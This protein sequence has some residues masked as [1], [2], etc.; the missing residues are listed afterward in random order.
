MTDDEIK[1][2]RSLWKWVRHVSE[3][4]LKYADLIYHRYGIGIIRYLDGNGKMFCRGYYT[5][6]RYRTMESMFRIGL[7]SEQD[8]MIMRLKFGDLDEF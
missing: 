1:E 2:C 7:I 4:H 3:D 6:R 5:H 8:I